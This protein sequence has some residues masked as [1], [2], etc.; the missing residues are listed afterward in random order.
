M[1]AIPEFIDLGHRVE[2]HWRKHRPNLVRELEAEGLLRDALL[3]V[4][5]RTRGELKRITATLEIRGD[6]SPEQ[7]ST[8]AWEMVRENPLLLPPEGDEEIG[9][10]WGEE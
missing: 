2:Q 1:N 7:I 10:F 3:V 4:E 8:I 6:L 5:E 9:D